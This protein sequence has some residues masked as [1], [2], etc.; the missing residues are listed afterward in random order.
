MDNKIDSLIEYKVVIIV[1]MIVV[2]KINI[3]LN[4]MDEIDII[5]SLDMEIDRIDN[6]EINIV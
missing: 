3:W 2:I 4:N 5:T 6:I 1:A